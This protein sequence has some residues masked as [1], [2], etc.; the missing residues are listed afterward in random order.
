MYPS[1][2]QVD[3]ALLKCLQ[4][5]FNNVLNFPETGT[6]FEQDGWF[7]K[8][9]FANRCALCKLKKKFCLFDCKHCP[10]SYDGHCCKEWEEAANITII[11]K[12]HIIAIYKVI[13]NVC[14]D[15]K[16][17]KTRKEF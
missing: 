11:T 7:L 14:I 1:K 16:L 2:H 10:I 9:C 6:Y 15:R 13:E 8:N 12:Q 3:T 5:Y 4:H 17:I